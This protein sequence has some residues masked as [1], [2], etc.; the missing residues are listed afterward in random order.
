MRKGILMNTLD[1]IR[2]KRSVRHFANEPVPDEIVRKILN[3]GR[4]AQSSKNEQ[5]W[6]FIL[7]Q[8]RERLVAL[9][10]CGSYAGHI[11][12]AA[13]AV[14]LVDHH[15]WSFDIGQAAAYLQLAAWDLGVSSCIAYFGLQDE[16]KA[17]LDISAEVS[18]EIGISFGYSAEGPGGVRH[19]GRKPLSEIVRK[20]HF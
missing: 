19:A 12:G 8:D 20:E 15:N 2:T 13:F 4:H 16:L 18:A 17:L 10:G 3:A 11:A 7:I 1:A 5:P 9:S 6:T 14:V